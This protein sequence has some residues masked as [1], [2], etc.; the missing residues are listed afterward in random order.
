MENKTSR[1]ALADHIRA[2]GIRK[3]DFAALVFVRNDHLSRWLTG[4]AMPGRRSRL[5]IE[6]VTEGAV[7]ADQWK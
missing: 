4:K 5:L 6:Q 7:K 1:I 2:L 3:Q